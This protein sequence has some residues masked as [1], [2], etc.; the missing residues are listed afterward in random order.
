MTIDVTSSVMPVVKRGHVLTC[1][2]LHRLGTGPDVNLGTVVSMY[3]LT[4]GRVAVDSVMFGVNPHVGTS[5]EVRGKGRTI[6]LLV[7]GSFTSTLG[8]DGHVGDCGRAH[9]SLSGG[10]ARRTGGVISG[11]SSLSREESVIVFGRS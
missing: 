4:R 9:G 1:R 3:K 7:R 6:S 5:K 8:G 10:V 2:K 11:L